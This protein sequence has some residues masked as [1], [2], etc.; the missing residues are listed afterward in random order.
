MTPD[1]IRKRYTIAAGLIIGLKVVEIARQIGVSRSWASREVNSPGVR[2]IIAELI[3]ENWHT[4][5]ALFSEVLGALRRAMQARTVRRHRG[6][7]VYGGP[8]YRVQLEAVRTFIKLVD[9]AGEIGLIK[10]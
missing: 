9:V 10:L 1:R 3:R 2:N 5:K 8:D 6:Q 4:I 7:I